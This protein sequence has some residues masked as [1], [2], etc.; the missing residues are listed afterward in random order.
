[1]YESFDDY[2]EYMRARKGKIPVHV[3]EFATDVNRH[4]FESPQSL[5]DSWVTSINIK[6]H[7]N[8][9]RPFNPSTTIEIELLGPMHDRNIVLKYEE[10][11]SYAFEGTKNP[12]NYADTYHGD[13]V[14]HEVRLT[15]GGYLLHEIL[16][17]SEATIK[18]V[19]KNITCNEQVYT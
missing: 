6:E 12:Y 13:I 9:E 5:H 14:C 19:C 10:I 15:E 11:E 4:D 17:A 8:K 16:M 3:Y 18:I 7:R 1:M 2:L